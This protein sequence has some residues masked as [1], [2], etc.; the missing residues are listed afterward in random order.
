ME[1]LLRALEA[2]EE[3][4]TAPPAD[5]DAEVGD[6]VGFTD[7]SFADFIGTIVAIDRDRRKVQVSAALFGGRETSMEMDFDK[8]YVKK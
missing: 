1:P 8:V 3:G 7:S 6:T 5:L 2:A 4:E